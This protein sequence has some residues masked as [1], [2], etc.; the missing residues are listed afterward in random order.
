MKSLFSILLLLL[1][2]VQIG[3][4]FQNNIET[5]VSKINSFVIEGTSTMHS[6]DVVVNE[7]HIDFMVSPRWFESME[8][9]DSGDIGQLKVTVPVR[10]LDGG[11]SR[12]NRDLR[13][14][15][16]EEEYPEIIF[17]WNSIEIE[18]T[19]E[20]SN[21]DMKVVGTLEIAGVEKEIEFSVIALLN[22]KGEMEVNGEVEMDMEDYGIDPPRALLGAIR[23]GN[24]ITLKFDL[25]IRGAE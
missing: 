12:M 3:Y 23:T 13:E 14:A 10:E 24:M 16:N 15:M 18:K 8:N 4:S 22:E 25:S 19:E 2:S 7:V 6:W 20:S 1:L 5:T 17:N 9:W 11:R 21:K